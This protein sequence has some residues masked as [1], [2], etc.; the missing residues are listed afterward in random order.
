MLASP[1][2][3]TLFT[4]TVVGSRLAQYLAPETPTFRG[5]P[6]SIW[7]AILGSGTALLAAVGTGRRRPWRGPTRTSAAILV[8]LALAWVA[9]MLLSIHHND[10][11]A[12]SAFMLPVALIALVLCWPNLDELRATLIVFAGVVLVAVAVTFIAHWTGL[13]PFRDDFMTRLPVSVLGMDY[14]WESF[15]GDANNAGTA[16]VAVGL[17]GL[18]RGRAWGA[19]MASMAGCLLVLSQSRTAIVAGVVGV[20][21]FV[22]LRLRWPSGLGRGWGF[23][24]IVPASLVAILVV[25]ADPSLNGRVPIWAE[26]LTLWSTQP[27][28]GVGTVGIEAEVPRMTGFAQDAHSVVFDPLVRY[29]LI[30]GG[31]SVLC[32]A[33][34]AFLCF[35]SPRVAGGLPASLAAASLI[36]FLTYTTF[37]WMYMTLFLW[38][39]LFATLLASESV[40]ASRRQMAP[41]RPAS[42][43]SA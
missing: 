5:H 25:L 26:Y 43:E 29:G 34:V 40:A 19:A 37:S 14:R 23:A 21:V 6:L 28:L 31:T 39:L 33:V 42:R 32:L 18:Y 13:R 11:F 24:L 1:L 15:F 9:S 16:M 2:Y 36:C 41:S 10:N 7:I 20:T 12:L 27:I 38:P 30:A 22:I 17:I 3:L 4:I 35:R 8:T